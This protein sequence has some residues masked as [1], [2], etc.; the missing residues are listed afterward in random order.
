MSR[1]GKLPINI[2]QGVDIKIQDNK[3]T[4]KGELGQLSQKLHPDLI[5]ENENN[6]LVLK[7]PT[8]SKEHR[9]MHGL[10]RSLINNMIV[11]VSEGFKIVLEMVGVG[12]KANVNGQVLE[13]SLGFS[14]DLFFELPPEVKV[15]A[16]QEKRA[17]P[18]V[19]LTSF[20]KQLLGQ[21]VAKIRSYRLP[22]PYKGKGIKF[23][24][25]VIRRKQGKTAAK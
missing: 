18:I 1:I 11:G 7:R 17:N 22:E 12:Y 25:E 21:V 2:P 23:Q 20:D 15:E 3:I 6:Q 4:V 9:S 19:T 14:H 24:N 13:M 5:I 16:A 8:D 10:Y